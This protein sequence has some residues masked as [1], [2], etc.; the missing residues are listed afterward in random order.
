MTMETDMTVE[1]VPT[2]L[3]AIGDHKEEVS[4]IIKDTMKQKR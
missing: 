4:K 3:K 2:L 1:I